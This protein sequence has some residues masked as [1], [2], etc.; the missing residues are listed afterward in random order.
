MQSL[1]QGV[2]DLVCLAAIHAMDRGRAYMCARVLEGRS[3]RG[4]TLAAAAGRKVLADFWGNLAD[5]CGLNVAP[6]KWKDDV[7][8]DHPFLQY[9]SAHTRWHVRRLGGG[10]S[11]N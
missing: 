6:K 8:A 9:D 2:W 7:P 3:Q 11:P 4:A 1:P 10:L 5:F